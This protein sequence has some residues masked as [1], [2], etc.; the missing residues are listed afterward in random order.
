MD[1]FLPDSMKIGS[2]PYNFWKY[3]NSKPERYLKMI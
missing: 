1:S 3:A 2:N